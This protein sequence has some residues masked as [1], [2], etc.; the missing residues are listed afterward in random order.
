MPISG[1]TPTRFLSGWCGKHLVRRIE[2][3]LYLPVILHKDNRLGRDTDHP[4]TTDGIDSHPVAVDEDRFFFE[5]ELD[6]LRE[7]GGSSEK[8]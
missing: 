4:I 3:F 5:E 6:R 7:R 1:S 8:V 2:I